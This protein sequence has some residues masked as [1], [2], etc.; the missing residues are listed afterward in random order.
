MIVILF[1]KKYNVDPTS[2]E[3]IALLKKFFKKNKNDVYEFDIK[4][5]R[6]LEGRSLRHDNKL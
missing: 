4:T 3:F 5:A 2:T 6:M 1:G